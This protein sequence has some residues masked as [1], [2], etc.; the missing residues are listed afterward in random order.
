MLTDDHADGRRELASG[1]RG[2]ILIKWVEQL[3]A[4]RDERR[5]QERAQARPWRVLSRARADKTA[6]VPRCRLD[7]MIPSLLLAAML[8]ATPKPVTIFVGPMVRDGFVDAD[9]GV[10]DSIKDLQAELRK[11]GAFSVVADQAAASLRLY[12]VSRTKAATGASSQIGT[13]TGTATGSQAQGTGTSFT[14]PVDVQRLETLLRVGPYERTFTGESQTSWSRCAS[15]V[16]KDLAV[17]LAANR[18]RLAQSAADAV[19]R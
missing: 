18:E 17:W 4:D 7:S 15:S 12:V 10:L 16:V 5:A 11:N 6:A 8:A 9:Q 13:A 1:L 19:P 14:I 3:L 2:P